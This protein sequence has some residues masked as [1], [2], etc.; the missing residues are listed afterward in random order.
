MC[1]A[2]FQASGITTR[3]LLLWSSPSSAGEGKRGENK[4]ANE[5][6]TLS[7]KN[8]MRKIKDDVIGVIRK[9]VF[10]EVTLKDTEDTF[11]KRK[12]PVQRP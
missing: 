10:E 7:F 3:F 1:L 12:P 2:L 9:L 4:E 11:R 8:A 5:Q 6:G